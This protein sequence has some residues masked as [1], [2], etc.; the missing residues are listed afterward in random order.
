MRSFSRKLVVFAGLQLLLLFFVIGFNQPHQ[1][2]YMRAYGMKQELL[3]KAE[4][5]RIVLVGGSNLALGMDSLALS[6]MTG[7]EVINMGLHA[8]L[9]RNLTLNEGIIARVR[10]GDLVIL[11][12]E[13]Q[14]FGQ[15]P[16]GEIAWQLLRVD[17]SSIS[18]MDPG[19]FAALSESALSYAGGQL[20]NSIKNALRLRFGQPEPRIYR[21]SGFN[22]HGDLI[23]HWDL[24]YREGPRGIP[25]LRLEGRHFEAAVEDIA[26][27]VAQI[28]KKGAE[29][30]FAFPPMQ[31]DQY[32]KQA[33]TIAEL[34]II[35]QRDLGMEILVDAE[36]MAFSET[37]FFDTAY[38]LNYEG[39]R[40][41]AALLGAAL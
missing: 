9:G 35:I 37:M 30:R 20:R 33:A 39:V 31:R 24:G 15:M 12:L 40:Q 10:A 17:P 3:E 16:A 13:Y 5:R 38:H 36:A 14:A 22:A 8:D 29:V 25:V 18:D 2:D 28:R 41:R 21:L 34:E 26:A 11:S 27:F 32:E 19:D 6:A 1:N 7:R 4:G 23:S